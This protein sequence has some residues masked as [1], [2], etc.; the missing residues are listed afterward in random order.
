MVQWIKDPTLSLLWLR[1]RLWPRFES[2]PSNF[3]MPQA[4]AKKS[5]HFSPLPHPWV[6]LEDIRLIWVRGWLRDDSNHQA[7]GH[8]DPHVRKKG[9]NRKQI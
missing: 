7:R 2:W 5:L 9:P 6:G 4:T 3:H 1:S 8:E